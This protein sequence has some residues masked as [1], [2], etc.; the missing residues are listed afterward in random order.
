MR[1]LWKLLDKTCPGS[2]P[3]GIIFLPGKR[4]SLPGFRWAPNTWMS[5]QEVDYPDPL[6]NM[7]RA[8]KLAPEGLL[9]H[10]PGFLLH[11]KNRRDILKVDDDKFRFPSDSTFLE[12]YKVQIEDS[13]SRSSK[14]V[15]PPEKRLAIILC[16]ERPRELR[17]IA[18]LV[19]IEEE[20]IQRNFHDHRRSKIYRV[21]I[22]S[23]VKIEREVNTD[24]LSGWRNYTTDSA[25]Q[26]DPMIC[27]EVLDSDQRWYV[28]GPPEPEPTRRKRFTEPAA[29]KKSEAQTKASVERT[30]TAATKG[31]T[32]QTKPIVPMAR[33]KQPNTSSVPRPRPVASGSGAGVIA[34]NGSAA[35]G[36]GSP[37]KTSTAKRNMS[38]Q[39]DRSLP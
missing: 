20:I 22:V 12:W 6:A 17:E 36:K 32:A 8:A 29:R 7:T 14:G 25:E 4:L 9:V 35:G 38:A 3:P 23:R 2:I 18:L 19:E 28:D 31:S 21:S 13:S 16:R 26:D 33:N 15:D 30:N 37:A 5:A 10:Y 39:S 24:R 34:M 27:G 1:D 11:A